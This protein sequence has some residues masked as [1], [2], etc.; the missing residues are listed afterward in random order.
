MSVNGLGLLVG[1]LIGDYV[2][3]NDWQARWKSA[4]RGAM[5]AYEWDRLIG[6]PPDPITNVKRH[7]G[8]PGFCKSLRVRVWRHWRPSVACTT[9]CLLYTFAVWCCSADWMTWWGV[10]ICFA[11]HWPIDRWGMA[12]KLMT[13]NGQEY[14]AI[15]PLSPFSIIIVDN[16]LHLLTLYLIAVACGQQ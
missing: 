8:E 5:N 1:H 2:S 6:P 10:L 7:E 15:G 16:T 4:R 14:F 11:A 13:L 12:R 9:H 3:Q